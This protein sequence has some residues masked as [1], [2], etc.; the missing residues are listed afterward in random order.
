MG[1]SE[2]DNALCTITITAEGMNWLV[3]GLFAAVIE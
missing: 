1:A 3:A 2:V